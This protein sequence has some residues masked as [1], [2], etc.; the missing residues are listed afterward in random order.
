[1]YFINDYYFLSNFYNCPVTLTLNNKTYTFR[2]S[3]AAYQAQ[4][5]PTIAGQFCFLT[6]AEAKDKGR[7][8]PLLVK[9]WDSYRVKAMLYALHAKFKNINLLSRL[10]EIKGE[11]VEDNHWGDTYW[12]RCNGEG[13]N[14][15]GQLL[16]LIRDCNNS[17][18]KLDQFLNNLN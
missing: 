12:G 9:D 4:K 7:I 11:I 6:G 10:L 18:I 16:M 5:N 2:N 17:K 1:M 3:E 14:M 15:L 13:I 8:I